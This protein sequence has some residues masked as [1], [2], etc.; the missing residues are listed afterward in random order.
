VLV[1]DE[2]LRGLVLLNRAHNTRIDVRSDPPSAWA[3]SGANFSSR[4]RQ[5]ALRGLAGLEWAAA[6][7]GTVGGAVYGNAGAFGGDVQ[8]SLQLAEIL[9]P[10]SGKETW[11]VERL[12][13]QYR[14]SSLKRE[15]NQA[16]I[17]SATF[18]L[19]P[20]EKEAIQARMEANTAQ[21]HGTQPP[22]ASMGSMFKNPQ[23]D[24]AGRLVE[25]CGLKGRR[26]G[27]AQISP[28]HANF[29]VNLGQARAADIWNL[30][31]LA[32]ETV[33]RE[34][35]VRLELEVEPLGEFAPGAAQ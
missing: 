17:L 4:A 31:E 32:R 12:A 1:S 5:A 3:E 18:H 11:S 6:V 28:V 26:S 8:A 16:V 20:G 30:I 13:Y 35:G 27:D 21:R 2:G 7:P 14:S 25:A 29:F 33:L 9:H 34:H 23:G 19:T 10:E 22:G 24:F 15:R